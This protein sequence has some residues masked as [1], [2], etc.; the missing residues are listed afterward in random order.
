LGTAFE[1]LGTTFE[2]QGTTF[3]S[4]GT[5]FESPGTAFES[6]GTTF[7]SPGTTSESQGT[8]FESPGVAS[9]S[10]GTAFET[11][12]TTVE[13]Q[14]VEKRVAQSAICNLQSTI[15]PYLLPTL[16]TVAYVGL[17]VIVERRNYLLAQGG[18]GLGAQVVLNPLRSLALI[19][20]PLP[21]TEHA[22]AGWLV[23]VG[24]I[25]AI[26]LFLILIR[27]V[28]LA[29]GVRHTQSSVVGRRSSVGLILALALTLLP[30]APFASPPDSRY[31]YLPVM[32]AAL[33]IT[34]RADHRRTTKDE[35]HR[36]SLA[37]RPSSFVLR[38]GLVLCS[39]FLVL[40]LAWWASGELHAREGRFAA[41]SGPGGSLWHVATAA[42]ADARPDR[43]VI[44][45]PPIAPPHIEAIV[46]LACGPD[47]R[48]KIV[49]PDQIEGAIKGHTIVI[50]FPNGSADIQRRT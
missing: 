2:S 11:Q 35:S 41:A 49:G 4:Q 25:V 40:A 30:T 36:T 18:Y 45:E 3:E 9:A 13:P 26:A 48:A 34:L 17:Q 28:R 32:A 20:A 50:A 33:L 22:N 27:D 44:V 16:M 42:C 43:M 38:R 24:A 47:V 23:P 39:W 15:R 7:E 29:V 21:G 37:L 12:G 19:V 6:P 14:E 1:S 5:A 31:L 8:T 46:G 10:L